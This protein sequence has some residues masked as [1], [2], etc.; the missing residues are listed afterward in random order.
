M[1]HCNSYTCNGIVL[2]VHTFHERHFTPPQFRLRG[3]RLEPKKI[4]L[5]PQTSASD[6]SDQ[7]LSCC[8]CCCCCVAAVSYIPEKVVVIP[9]QNVTVYC[10]FNDRSVNASSAIWSIN[11]KHL[12]PSRQYSAVNRWVDTGP[13]SY[14]K[15]TIGC[16]SICVVNYFTFISFKFF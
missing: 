11:L 1:L 5:K 13:S 4:I 12:I 3:E 8:C 2:T 10:V 14:F 6:R 7:Q 15:R 9:G 16:F